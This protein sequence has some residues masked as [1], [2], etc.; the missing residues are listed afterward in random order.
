[1]FG[2]V[3]DQMLV[4]FLTRSTVHTSIKTEKNSV[5]FYWDGEIQ[6]YSTTGTGKYTVRCY[7]DGKTY[8]TVSQKTIIYFFGVV[9][10][11]RSDL[12]YSKTANNG[13]PGG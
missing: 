3:L 8:S 13:T 11:K 10:S 5:Q 12:P 2:Q 6:F 7:S 9:V 4:R 1:M